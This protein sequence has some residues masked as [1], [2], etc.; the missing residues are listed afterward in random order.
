MMGHSICPINIKNVLSRYSLSYLIIGLNI[1]PFLS[2]YARIQPYMNND[3]RQQFSLIYDQYIDKIYRFVYLKVDSV[4]LAQDLTS[5]AFVKAWESYQKGKKVENP[6]AFLY[7]IAGNLVIDYYRQKDR[8]KTISMEAVAQ[9]ADAT[10]DSYQ[11]AALNADIELVKS[12]IKNMPKDY[13]DIIIW[14][15][16]EDMPASQIAQLVNKPAG[17]VRVMIHRALEM[18]KKELN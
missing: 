2:I 6:N 1:L 5:K 15:Y 17:T 4:E 13:Q 18:L 7:R 8:T 16:L 11:M 14:Y 10:K 9:I 3:Y 12:A